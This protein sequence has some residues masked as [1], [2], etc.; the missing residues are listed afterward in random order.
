MSIQK[1]KPEQI[2]TVLR[3]IEVQMA[4]G[5]TVPQACK[6]AE[7]HTQTYYRW[8]KEYGGLKLEQAKRLKELEKENARLKRVVAELSLEKQVLREVAPGKL[9]SPKRRCCAVERAE[10][11]YGMSERHACRLLGQWRGTQR[12]EPMHRLD[13]DELTQAII[14][15]AANYGRYGYRRITALLRRAGWQVGKDRVQRIWRR[16]GLKVPQK[17]RPRRR[18]WLN[19][20]SCI[21]LRPER[22]NHVWSY[23]FVSDRTEDGRRLRILTLI[24]EYT[25]ECLALPVERRMGSRQVMETLADVMLWRG[26]PE[27]IR[28][29]NGPEFVAKQLR[30]WLGKLGTGTLYIEPGSPWENG[31]CESFNGKL[32]DECLNGEIFYSLKEAQIVI[33]GWR[34]EYNT[35]RPHSALGY[36]PPAPG[37]Y[38]PVLKPVSQPQAVI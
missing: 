29:D 14:A 9:L 36:R 32:R 17:Q 21:R 12:Y 3:Q 35:V 24:D 5:K 11:G 7:I 1:N 23:D 16:E 6:E 18:L 22:R 25:R 28:S 8:R 26:V 38:N 20:G 33:Q 27:H 34:K 13:E 10:Q 2:V 31:Y 19:D 15:L 30:E 37:A 4:N